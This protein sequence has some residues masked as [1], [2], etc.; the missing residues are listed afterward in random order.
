M[1]NTAFRNHS[2]ASLMQV[3]QFALFVLLALLPMRQAFASSPKATASVSGSAIR[4]QFT[5]LDGAQCPVEVALAW[6]A[7]GGYT[8]E[9]GNCTKS[10]SSS[11]AGVWSD[12]CGS[13]QSSGICPCCSGSTT[14]TSNTSVFAS[15]TTIT[16]D[17]NY[18]GES[19]PRSS[20][21]VVETVT[22]STYAC[23]CTTGGTCSVCIDHPEYYDDITGHYQTKNQD[24]TSITT[25]DIYCK[26][27]ICE[28]TISTTSSKTTVFASSCTQCDSSADG[29]CR[30]SSETASWS[31]K[32]ANS[33]ECTYTYSRNL[34]AGIH[35]ENRTGTT[36]IRVTPDA[37]GFATGTHSF[38]NG[39]GEFSLKI[40]RLF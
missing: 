31:W 14:V 33:G 37:Q 2:A 18:K 34:K 7:T 32:C 25:T 9:N 36:C 16:T 23:A 8:I 11:I 39:T 24:Q 17:Y 27:G 5:G 28:K 15:G 4:I 22:S 29:C 10:D 30:G 13:F 35:K 12:W 26:N 6:E 21:H 1:D 40:K 20:T 3:F 19:G 38:T